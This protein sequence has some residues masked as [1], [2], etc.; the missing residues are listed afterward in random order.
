M[1]RV[2]ILVSIVAE[3]VSPFMAVILMM[4]ISSGNM[5]DHFCS[6]WLTGVK[7]QMVLNSS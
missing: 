4:K 2:E 7:I 5:T 1:K 3:E 6:Q